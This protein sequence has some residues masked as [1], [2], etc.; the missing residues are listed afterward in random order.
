MNELFVFASA[1]D[2]TTHH[3]KIREL[4][5]LDKE[6]AEMEENTSLRELF[7][8]LEYSLLRARAKNLVKQLT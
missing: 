2:L 8:N 5:R 4:W 3:S 7:H 6:I 1:N